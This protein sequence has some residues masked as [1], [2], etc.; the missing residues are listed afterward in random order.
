MQPTLSGKTRPAC[1]AGFASAS[2]WG[3]YAAAAS[4]YPESRKPCGC[5]KAL[6]EEQT[7]TEDCI[8]VHHLHRLRFVLVPEPEAGWPEQTGKMICM[9]EDDNGLRTT[10]FLLFLIYYF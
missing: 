5:H 9:K 4:R 7:Q 2:L 1:S 10:K 8:H 6:E 3:R